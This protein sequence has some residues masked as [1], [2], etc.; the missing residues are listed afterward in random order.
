MQLLAQEQERKGALPRKGG[1]PNGVHDGGNE[2]DGSVE[3]S[4]EI[5]MRR[6]MAD[7]IKDT[8]QLRKGINSLTRHALVTATQEVAKFV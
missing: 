1:K 2:D 8:A 5:Q 4:E 3:E 6:T 7:L